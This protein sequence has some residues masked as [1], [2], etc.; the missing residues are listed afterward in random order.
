MPDQPPAPERGA[1]ARRGTHPS[2]RGGE[3]RSR[4]PRHSPATW[5]APTG[6]AAS[7]AAATP[8]RMASSRPRSIVHDGLPA[9]P[10]ARRLREP[11]TFQACVRF[12][13]PGPDLPPDIDDV[14][15]GSM[16]IKLMGV[17]GPKLMD[18]E[19][20][21][22]DF[23]CVSHADLRHARTR[24]R[25]PSCSSGASR[26]CRSSI[27]STPLDP[28]LLDFFMQGLWNETQYNPLGTRYWSCVPYLLGEGQAMMYS[29]LP[30][31]EVITRHSGRAVRP[32]AAQL[33]ARQHGGD[34]GAARTSSSISWSRCRPTRIGCRSRMPSVRW[35][36]KLS[37]FIP[38]ATMHIPRQKFDTPAHVAFAK[39]LSLNPWHCLPEH[40]P[41]GNQSRA[42]R[43]MYSSCRLCARTRNGT[44]HIEPTGTSCSPNR[45]H[46]ER[47]PAIVSS[48]LG[49][50]SVVGS[51]LG[52][53]EHVLLVLRSPACHRPCPSLPCC[54]P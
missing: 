5:S 3:P 30:R 25:T 28:H 4:S 19:K 48:G 44:P 29:F 14:G 31:S 46:L 33:S 9:A 16:T 11:R 10:A 24:A 47:L 17:P 20:H 40:R 22:Q 35:P 27:S 39:V 53:L 23:L 37:P 13:G 15:F 54:C 21:T 41:L 38:V 52:L 50:L 51:V 1:P 12:S 6:R 7:S 34:A 45:R 32:G 2:R 49:L 18:D 42:R 43:R 26:D 36:E 8:R